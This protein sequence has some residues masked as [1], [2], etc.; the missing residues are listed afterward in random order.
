MVR[1]PIDDDV[2]FSARLAE[3]D[4]LVLPGSVVE[5][6]GWLR[7]SLTASDAMVERGLVGFQRALDGAR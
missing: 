2:E 6:P 5:V 3:L 7:V 4:V 1:A